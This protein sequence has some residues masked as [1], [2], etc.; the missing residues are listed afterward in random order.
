MAKPSRPHGHPHPPSPPG[1]TGN[2]RPS[3]SEPEMRR[4]P[5][6]VECT[7]AAEQDPS[8]SAD[9]PLA[10]VQR[11]LAHH[12]QVLNE[13]KSMLEQLISAAASNQAEK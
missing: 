2:P 13:M 11:T 6:P 12:G 7:A 3:F 9:A 10:L 1:R 4:W 8:S 5:H